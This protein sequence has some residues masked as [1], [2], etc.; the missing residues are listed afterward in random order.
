MITILVLDI[1]NYTGLAR[2]LG[3][4]RITEVMNRLFHESGQLLKRNGSW[5]QKYIGDAVMAFWVH[6]DEGGPPRE[7]VPPLRVARRAR[8]VIAGS[9]RNSACPDRSRSARASTPASR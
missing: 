2:E 9:T 1:R 3:E 4:S 5:A 6:E 8:G 7:V